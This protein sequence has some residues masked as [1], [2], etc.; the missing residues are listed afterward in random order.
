MTRRSP[1]RAIVVLAA[2]ALP[3]SAQN[4]KPGLWEMNNTVQS[5]NAIMAQAMAHMQKQLAGMTPEQRKNIDDKIAQH[6]GMKIETSG[7]GSMRV[8]MC[9][10]KE[11]IQDALFGPQQSGNC[12]HTKAPMAGKVLHYTFSCTNPVSSGQGRVTF[13]GDSAYVSKL[14]VSSSPMGKQ[15]TMVLDS[16]ARWLGADCGNIQPISNAKPATTAPAAGAK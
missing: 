6:G 10:T 15:E 11:V 16:T 7:E 1:A 14:T 3:A 2:M 13:N 12:T 4:I 8:K 9:L 5:D